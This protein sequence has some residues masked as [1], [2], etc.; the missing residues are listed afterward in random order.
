MPPALDMSSAGRGAIGI[1]TAGWNVVNSHT[2]HLSQAVEA[3]KFLYSQ[4]YLAGILNSQSGFPVVDGLL[5]NV[6][7]NAFDAEF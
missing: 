3:W 2:R 7:K 5:D 6:E 1:N 4:D